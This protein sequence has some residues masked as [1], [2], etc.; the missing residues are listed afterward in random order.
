ML[1]FYGIPGNALV[2]MLCSGFLFLCFIIVRLFF[3]FIVW[4]NKSNK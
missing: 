2:I 3:C 4:G 1:F